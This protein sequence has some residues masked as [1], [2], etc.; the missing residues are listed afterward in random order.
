MTLSP[1]TV[2]VHPG[3][4]AL[5]PGV[6]I[7]T[8]QVDDFNDFITMHLQYFFP[9]VYGNREKN[10]KFRVFFCMFGFA[11]DAPEA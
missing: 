2:I 9:N 8:I 10:W 7:L 5:V 4:W 6:M 11:Y 3:A 1:T